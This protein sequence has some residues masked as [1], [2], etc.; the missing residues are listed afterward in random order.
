MYCTADV[1]TQRE[2]KKGEKRRL[3]DGRAGE[4]LRKEDSK[5]DRQT[6]RMEEIH[7]K[8]SVN[9]PWERI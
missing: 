7:Y 6:D 1:G 8:L 2:R 9:S 5:G 4:R 3:R